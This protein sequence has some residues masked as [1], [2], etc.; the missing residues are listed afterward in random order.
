MNG[1]F[2]MSFRNAA[3]TIALSV[4]TA[5]GLLA[6]PSHAGADPGLAAAAPGSVITYTRTQTKAIDREFAENTASTA[7]VNGVAAV[8]CTAAGGVGSPIIGTA[9]GAQVAFIGISVQLVRDAAG[10]AARTNQCLRVD[11][12]PNPRVDSPPLPSITNGPTCVD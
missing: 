9:C 4:A 10:K 7:T 1:G 2:I 8:L 6:V 5:F 11:L 12:A 3:S